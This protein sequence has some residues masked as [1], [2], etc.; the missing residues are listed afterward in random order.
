MLITPRI[1]PVE[2][3]L[4]ALRGTLIS[5]SL[6]TS[7]NYY[8]FTNSSL[9]ESDEFPP[10]TAAHESQSLLDLGPQRCVRNVTRESMAGNRI[11]SQR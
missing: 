2:G 9:D 1:L 11:T 10:S 5:E 3:S 7:C 4:P 8:S 6:R